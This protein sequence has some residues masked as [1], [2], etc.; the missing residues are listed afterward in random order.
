MVLRRLLLLIIMMISLNL[1]QCRIIIR[2]LFSKNYIKSSTNNRNNLKV[3]ITVSMLSICLMRKIL[4]ST[5]HQ[6]SCKISLV[7]WKLR[8]M[9]L[10]LVIMRSNRNPSSLGNTRKTKW[11]L[12]TTMTYI[13]RVIARRFLICQMII[14]TNNNNNKRFIFNS[15]RIL[16]NSI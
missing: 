11:L 12:R 4:S 10:L 3:I 6:S 15:I 8:K 1:T 14:A 13:F 16:G 2:R 9:L 5:S 7:I